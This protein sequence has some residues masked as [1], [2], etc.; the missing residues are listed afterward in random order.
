MTS[1]ITPR[2]SRATFAIG[3]EPTARRVVDLLNESLD[4][5]QAAVAAYERADGRWDVSAHF[6]EAP[7]QAA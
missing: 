6:A 3:D 4:D 2:T 1:P 7:D 5:D